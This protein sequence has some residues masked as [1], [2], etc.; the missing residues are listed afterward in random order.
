MARRRL[1]HRRVGTTLAQHFRRASE[2]GVL[3]S[4]VAQHYQLAGSDDEAATYFKL[5]GDRARAL[6]A[7]AEALAHFRSALALG[8]PDAAALHEAV[9]DL[10]TLRGVY[11]QAIAS[12]ETAAALCDPGMIWNLEHKLGGVHHRRGEWRSAEIHYESALNALE[13]AGKSGARPGVYADWSLTVHRMG[14]TN[15]ALDLAYRALDFAEETADARALAQVHNTL[16]ILSSSRGDLDAA[17]EHL[18]RSIE[19][20]E[21]LEDV[22][23][24]MA[25]LNN[26]ARTYG[27]DGAFEQ[28]IARTETAL[29]LCVSRGDRHREA[30]LRNNLADLL[31]AA[32][33]PEDSMSQLEQAVTIFAEIDEAEPM[34]PEIWKLTEW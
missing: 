1:L 16:G 22:G 26:L 24:R 32:G 18:E 21:T 8:Y 15:R 28:A 3:P 25:A 6:Y 12:Y 33:R 34:R 23:A 14:E 10:H 4:Q 17:Q 13:K 7:N 29:N 11:D 31:H 2:A 30:A 5:A 9:G 19:L 27:A 20:A